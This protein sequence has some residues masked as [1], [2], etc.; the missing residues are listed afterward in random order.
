MKTALAPVFLVLLG[1]HARAQCANS[2]TAF[3]PPCG[4]G[5]L[6]PVRASCPW[7]P[8][9]PGPLPE[10]LVVAGDFTTVGNVA[11]NNIAVWEPATGAWSPLG[12]GCK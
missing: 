11:A 10:R 7:D 12:S 1:A 2:W 3:G 9:G 5:G 6:G 4:V 8:D